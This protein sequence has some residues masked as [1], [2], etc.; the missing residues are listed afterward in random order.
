MVL[1]QALGI[2]QLSPPLD[3]GVEQR[4][5]VEGPEESP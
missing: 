1:V 5:K 4:P 2:Q 3:D